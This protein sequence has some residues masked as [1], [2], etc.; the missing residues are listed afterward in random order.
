[1]PAFLRVQKAKAVRHLAD[2][3][4]DPAAGEPQKRWAMA[5]LEDITGKDLLGLCDPLVAVRKLRK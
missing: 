1:M 3:A 5:I 2:Q 4:L